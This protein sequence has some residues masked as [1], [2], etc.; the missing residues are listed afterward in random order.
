M[1]DEIANSGIVVAFFSPSAVLFSPSLLLSSLLVF[2]KINVGTNH[3]K[4]Q[5]NVL[6]RIPCFHKCRYFRLPYHLQSLRQNPTALQKC[7][8]IY[9]AISETLIVK[10]SKSVPHESAHVQLA[11]H[12]M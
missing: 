11:M 5:R 12:I 3:S 8:L 7:R 6:L 9:E 4:N 2:D 10:M 1:F